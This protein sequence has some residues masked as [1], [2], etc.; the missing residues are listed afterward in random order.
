MTGHM[1]PPAWLQDAAAFAGF[2]DGDGNVKI[3]GTS[4]VLRINQAGNNQVNLDDVRRATNA[5][6]VRVSRPATDTKAQMTEWA[7]CG[8][9]AIRIAEML[10]P[11]SLMTSKRDQL[12]ILAD[13]PN[14][15]KR[16]EDRARMVERVS[17]L[18]HAKD[19][20]I[21]PSRVTDAYIGGLFTAE[22]CVAV[23]GHTTRRVSIAQKCDAVLVAMRERLGMGRIHGVDLVFRGEEAIRLLQRIRPFVGPGKLEQVDLALNLTRDNKEETVKSLR[24]AKGNAGLAR[25]KQAMG[26][27]REIKR[28]GV[29]VGFEARLRDNWT[30]FT[31]KSRTLEEKRAMA[32]AKLEEFRALPHDEVAKPV[33]RRAI[34]CYPV[35]GTR[36]RIPGPPMLYPGQCA[37]ASA[38]VEEGVAASNIN[39]CL[40]GG[41]RRVKG[42][43]F[44]YLERAPDP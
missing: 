21:D 13:W 27:V 16:R 41:L 5:G 1:A 42:Y 33:S 18:K 6:S 11:H 31:E 22:G 9:D 10:A 17:Q 39:K 2:F 37:A 25:R 38:L 20:P 26:G 12:L 32:E 8:S 4:P 36:A 34:L 7:V 14:Y 28:D 24:R 15:S 30:S 23:E 35:D 43:F 40:K 29:V 44:E 19:E 3:D